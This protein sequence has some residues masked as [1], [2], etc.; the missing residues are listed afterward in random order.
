MGV[1]LKNKSKKK[2][3]CLSIAVSGLIPLEFRPSQRNILA[4]SSVSGG[5]LFL[6][7]SAPE[8]WL[9][10]FWFAVSHGD[11]SGVKASVLHLKTCPRFCFPSCWPNKIQA[12]WLWRGKIP[13]SLPK[14]PS[15]PC[16]SGFQ[17]LFS[18]VSW[19]YFHRFRCIVSYFNCFIAGLFLVI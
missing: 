4:S 3:L 2:G 7:H 1:A 12:P 10:R 17:L 13:S 16:C 14:W 19:G 11:G 9:F 5:G 15:P 18:V 8:L 6:V